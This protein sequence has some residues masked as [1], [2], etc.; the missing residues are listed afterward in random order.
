MKILK[1]THHCGFTLVNR[2]SLLVLF[3]ALAGTTYAQQNEQN[4][5]DIS[6]FFPGWVCQRGAV[7]PDQGCVGKIGLMR[8]GRSAYSTTPEA[9][10]RYSRIL[11]GTEE[12]P[13]VGSMVAIKR[14][15]HLRD[16]YFALRD[17]QDVSGS[18]KICNQV[19]CKDTLSER[20][21]KEE[22][23]KSLLS[24]EALKKAHALKRK[25]K[26]RAGYI[27]CPG[28]T[29]FTDYFSAG[30]QVKIL[31]YQQMQYAFFILVQII[32][33]E[34]DDPEEDEKRYTF[35]RKEVI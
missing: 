29:E 8:L 10:R 26:S 35:D 33:T 11:F 24:N 3:L 2:L 23:V 12:L 32:K 15:A 25:T 14:S 7:E 31:G 27:S 1:L 9:I 30:T 16:S 34:S 4:R 5:R 21:C 28:P 6:G 17:E 18:A 20:Y 19:G 22:D 13:A